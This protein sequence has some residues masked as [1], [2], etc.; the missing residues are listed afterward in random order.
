MIETPNIPLHVQVNSYRV[1]LSAPYMLSVSWD[2]PDNNEKFD[3]DHFKIHI[4]LPEQESYIA[5][6]TSMESEYHF[7]SDVI[8]PQTDIVH[9]V[10]TTVSK[11]SQQG[12]RSLAVEFEWA[13]AQVTISTNVPD[14]PHKLETTFKGYTNMINGKL[15]IL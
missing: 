1:Q 12:N 6:G 5:N 8:P 4:M 2:V 11:C 7:H 3:F 9:V 14:T 15:I 10:V 13:E